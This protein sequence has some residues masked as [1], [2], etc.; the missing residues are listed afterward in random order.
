MKDYIITVTNFN[1]YIVNLFR[2]YGTKQAVRRKLQAMALED[3]RECGSMALKDFQECNSMAH[4]VCHGF[5]PSK[6]QVYESANAQY[7]HQY[8]LEV[9]CSD[10]AILYTATEFAAI[11][12]CN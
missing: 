2:F 6:L 1:N 5:K 9:P 3:C 10:G 12:S 8:Q 11:D 4:E 7:M